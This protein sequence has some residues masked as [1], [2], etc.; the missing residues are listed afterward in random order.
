MSSLKTASL[1]R[2]PSQCI[3][4]R[5]KHVGYM[6]S[7]LAKIEAMCSGVDEALILDINGHVAEGPGEN[8]L[9]V[10]NGVLISPTTLNIL[11]G[12]TRRAAIHLARE[13][14]IEVLEKDLTLGDVYTADEALLSG[15][16]AEIVPVRVVDGRTIGKQVP[17][18]ITSQLMTDFRRLVQMEGTPVY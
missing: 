1:R 10:K 18:P 16:G 11:D 12:V 9:I 6:N 15:T 17:G 3:D 7:I 13:R 14:G 2:V 4:S 5:V 8:F